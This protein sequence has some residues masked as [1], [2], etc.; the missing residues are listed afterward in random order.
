MTITVDGP[1]HSRP[2]LALAPPGH[3]QHVYH[4][5]V[6][7][8]IGGYFV[9]GRYSSVNYQIVLYLASRVMVGLWHRMFPHWKD[10][11]RLYPL[12]AAG[13][14]G[15]VM[16]LFEESPEVLHPSL[17]ASMNEIYRWQWSNAGSERDAI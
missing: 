8:A 1:A 14:W 17:R 4:S 6:A 5:F 12:A 3:A 10:H 11:P 7:G 15:L 9:W 2:V 13:V 16:A